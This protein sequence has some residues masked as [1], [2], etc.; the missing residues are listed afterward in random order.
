MKYIANIFPAEYLKVAA[1][2]WVLLAN[3]SHAAV[4]AV[5]VGYDSPGPE[6]ATEFIVLTNT[7]LSPI[8]LNG[9]EVDDIDP[10]GSSP[11]VFSSITIWP[12]EF[13]VASQSTQ[14]VLE[15]AWGQTI[16]TN[17]LYFQ[18]TGNWPGFNNSGDDVTIR[19]AGSNE[20][21][22][23]TY[24]DNAPEGSSLRL[25]DNSP[26]LA[27]STIP[28]PSTALLGGLALLGLFRRRR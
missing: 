27:F 7:G 16:P 9:Y 22:N 25:S 20:I 6:S 1:T 12:G 3:N 11:F 14:T 24:P 5:E 26:I 15:G 21:F 28:E 17:T 13:L 19:D 23:Q 10:G 4:T 2:G 18:V 8:N